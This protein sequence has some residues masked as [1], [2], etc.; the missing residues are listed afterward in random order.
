MKIAVASGKGGTGKT[1]IAT[2]LVLSLADLSGQDFLRTL[3]PKI[4]N[5]QVLYLDCDVE[6]PNAHLF[7]KPEFQKEKKAELKTPSIDP[8]KCRIC[9]KCVE[10]CQFNA[11]ASA[12][13]KIMVFPQ[14]CH[15]CGS[16]ALICPESAIAEVPREIGCL[17]MGLVYPY[18]AFGQGEL[19][20][21]EP[22]AVPVI[23]QLKSW[24][25]SGKEQIAILDSPPGSSC[26]VVEVISDADALILVTEPTP[27]GLHDLKL[28]VGVARL[29]EI[30]FGVIINRDGIGDGSVDAYCTK[31]NIPVLMR[32]PFE[33]EIFEGIA[34]GKSLL[35][36]K[37]D[38]CED[39]RAL[40]AAYW[41]SV[42]FGLALSIE[43]E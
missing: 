33:R 31:E 39:F 19:T 15:G 22:V 7:L 6:A 2:S 12:G 20:I 3:D 34:R 11:L 10:V 43:G 9:G 29:F 40:F 37:S 28:A 35:E 42:K 13:K 16:C 14:L 17:K 23:K 5:T 41:R 32:I 18:L 8:E 4:E 36:I 1:T 27:F 24:A 26:P 38:L 25:D 30:P 21:G